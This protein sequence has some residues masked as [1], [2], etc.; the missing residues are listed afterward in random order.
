MVSNWHFNFISTVPSVAAWKVSPLSLVTTK[1]VETDSLL[2]FE[3]ESFEN[4]CNSHWSG[5]CKI[6]NRGQILPIEEFLHSRTLCSK[7]T[8]DS[9]KVGLWNKISWF[10]IMW[11]SPPP[12]PIRNWD[13]FVGEKWVFG[14]KNRNHY[15][16][17]K[18]KWWFLIEQFIKIGDKWWRNL[19]KRIVR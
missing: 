6:L 14:G 18:I 17:E 8:N 5:S 13:N 16:A 2:H 11:I 9:L 15:V 1:G 4:K 7:E 19:H 12:S 10:E 3:G